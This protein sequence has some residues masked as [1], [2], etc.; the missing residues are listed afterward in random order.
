MIIKNQENKVKLYLLKMIKNM[1]IKNKMII[2]FME[3]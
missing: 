1:S 2:Y 3:M